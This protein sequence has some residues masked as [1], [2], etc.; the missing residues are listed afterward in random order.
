MKKGNK[1]FAL[2]GFVP[3]AP[4]RCHNAALRRNGKTAKARTKNHARVLRTIQPGNKSFVGIG[5]Q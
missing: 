3:I 4:I 2:R 5:A 1:N